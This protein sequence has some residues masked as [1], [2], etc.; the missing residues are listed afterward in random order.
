MDGG[1]FTDIVTMTVLKEPELVSSEKRLWKHWYILHQRGII[2]R[3][4]KSD[5]ILLK[6]EGQVKLTDFGFSSLP[7]HKQQLIYHPIGVTREC[8]GRN[9]LIDGTRGY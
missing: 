7:S 6:S 8:N 1:C 2:H 3:D 9:T 5:K 4:V